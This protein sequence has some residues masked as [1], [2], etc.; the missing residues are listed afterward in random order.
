VKIS[1]EVTMSFE[2]TSLVGVSCFI[3]YQ[4]GA[5]AIDGMENLPG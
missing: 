3:D 5:M 2:Q 4:T 1:E